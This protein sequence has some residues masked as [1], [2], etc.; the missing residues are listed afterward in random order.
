M[1]CGG[2]SSLVTPPL[3]QGIDFIL[4]DLEQEVAQI[5]GPAPR[6]IGYQLSQ[7][8]MEF[9]ERSNG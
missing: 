5:L 6:E 1:L 2:S 9:A 4:V 3:H 7:S 8:K